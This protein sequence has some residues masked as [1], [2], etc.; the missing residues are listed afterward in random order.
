[1]YDT[2]SLISQLLA[3]DVEL[4][5][6]LSHRIQK[7]FHIGNEILVYEFLVFSHWV[8]LTQINIH[9]LFAPENHNIS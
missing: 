7:F 3:L 4:L 6:Q 9:A 8:K 1:M 5:E 2:T